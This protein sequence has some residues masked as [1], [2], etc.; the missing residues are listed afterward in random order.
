MKEVLQTPES[1]SSS[2]GQV[3]L[4]SMQIKLVVSIVNLNVQM[5][6]RENIKC[7][8]TASKLH[9]YN[10]LRPEISSVLNIE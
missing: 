5:P 7:V 3:R 4:L 6:Q 10:P 8:T 1:T 2:V 9:Y